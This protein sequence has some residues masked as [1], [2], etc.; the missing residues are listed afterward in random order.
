[1]IFEIDLEQVYGADDLQDLLEE[2]LPVPDYYGR[3]LDA[4]Y[5]VLTEGRKE[6]WDI[7]FHHTAEART[8][9]EKYMK[10]LEKMCRRA[11][12]ETQKLKVSFD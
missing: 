11:E 1:M 7:R 10:S 5:D 3:N 8:V 6:T 9:I 4:L 12:K 2:I